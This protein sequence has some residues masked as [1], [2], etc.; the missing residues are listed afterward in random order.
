[1]TSGNILLHHL[2][3]LNLATFNNIML[4]IIDKVK[5]KT[6]SWGLENRQETFLA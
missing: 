4:K 3:A 2:I 1:V 6:A 5:E